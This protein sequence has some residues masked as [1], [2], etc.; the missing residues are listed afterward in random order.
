MAT[1]SRKGK[2]TRRRSAPRALPGNVLTIPELK[3][4]FSAVD[5]ETRKILK[6]NLS[7]AEQV[8]KFQTVW[9]SIFHKPV[10]KEAAEAYLQIKRG[11]A[12][13]AVRK[14]VTRKMKGGSTP[15]AGAPLD[16]S[17]RPGVDGVHGSFPAYQTSGLSFYNTVNQNG[18]AQECGTKDF[19]P[20]VPE[21]VGSNEVPIK[22]GGGLNDFLMTR[23][24]SASSPPGVFSD[25]AQYSMGRPLGASPLPDQN[26]LTKF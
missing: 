16:F 19:T 18:M 1:E 25:M 15:L 23:S 6:E 17:T 12:S 4:A 24:V 10:T 7:Q 5:T 13:R 8:K 21:M 11:S 14:G 20:K 3:Q 2:S 22:S 26:K 9:R